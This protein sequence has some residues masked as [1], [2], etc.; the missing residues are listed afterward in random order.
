[1]NHLRGS[2]GTKSEIKSPKKLTVNRRS[3]SELKL[4]PDG[5]EKEISTGLDYDYITQ[6]SYGIFESLNLVAPR[7]QGGASSEDLGENS[8]LYE[9]LI[10]NNVFA[11]MVFFALTGIFL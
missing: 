4:N 9:F 11:D 2:H 7:V 8:D 1:M 5:S 6:Y 3:Q 10:D